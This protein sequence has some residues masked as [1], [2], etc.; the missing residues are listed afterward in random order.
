MTIS[1]YPK[2]G[3]T[4][5]ED[6]T[7][8]LLDK[9]HDNFVVSGLN[10]SDGGGLT[11]NVSSGYALINGYLVSS[12]ATESVTLTDN[13]TNYIYLELTRDGVTNNITN[14]SVVAYTSPQVETDRCYLGKVTTSGGA[15]S[16]ITEDRRTVPVTSKIFNV[17]SDINMNGYDITNITANNLSISGIKNSLDSHIADTSNPHSVTESQIYPSVLPFLVDGSRKLSGNIQFT[18]DSIYSIGEATAKVNEIYVHNL[19][20]DI[21]NA[22]VPNH[23]SQ[24]AS[25]N[26]DAL[27]S[28]SIDSDM[29]IDGIVT[30]TKLALDSAS[31]NKVSGG[32]LSI[33]A[34]SIQVNA[35]ATDRSHY[36]VFDNGSGV[37]TLWRVYTNSSNQILFD[38]Y[39]G[40]SWTTKIKMLSNGT[41]N[42][43]GL[44]D[45]LGTLKISIGTPVAIKEEL[46]L[47][48]IN[49]T[50][51]N[52]N[53]SQIGSSTEA[54]A[55]LFSHT[56]TVDTISELT[57]DNGVTIDGLTIKDGKISNLYAKYG[58][59]SDSSTAE[60]GT[61]DT[62][63]TLLKTIQIDPVASQRRALLYK[64][65]FE[66]GGVSGDGLTHRGYWKVTYT[67]EGGTETTIVDNEYL[68]TSSPTLS[69]SLKEYN[70]RIPSD[71]GKY[72]LIKIYGKVD[73]VNFAFY[74]RN[75]YVYSW[76]VLSLV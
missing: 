45:T 44:N 71:E 20:A 3:E 10:L 49:L 6:E 31:L 55:N 28:G 76:D 25:G 22:P 62:S 50:L 37:S 66:V 21:I 15:I 1:W 52:D 70:V 54:L 48:D 63:Y 4:I 75:A 33:A 40:S 30:N 29:L 27:P 51:L 60:A 61:S 74:V 17:E 8:N 5:G 42:L 7:A 13:A 11:L 64:I 19:I 38:Y 14:I 69:Y 46:R 47:D 35:G 65:S 23:A 26:S 2:S 73:D 67:K 16:N 24:H 41:L 68:A 53:V 32:Y 36:F 58:A 9:F 43:V 72:V 39:D 18:A 12:D 56:I 59:I 57:A 34:S